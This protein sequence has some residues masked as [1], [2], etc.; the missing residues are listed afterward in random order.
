MIEYEPGTWGLRFIFRI[1]G[2]VLQKAL[3]FGIP[4]SIVAVILNIFAPRVD[5]EGVDTVWSNYTFVLG[6]LIVFR[7]NL[8]YSRFWEGASLIQQVRG[9]WLNAVS[10]LIAF[11]NQADGKKSDVAKFQHLL[12]RLMSMLHCSA[13]QQI[14]EVEDDSFEIL[15]PT[16]IDPSRLQFLGNNHTHRCEI[17]LQWIQRLIVEAESAGTLKVAPPILSRVYQ[18]LSRGIVNLHNVRRIKEVPFPFPYAQMITIMMLIHLIVTPV[19]ASQLCTTPMWSGSLTL[20]V[21]TA[22]WS[23]QYIALEIEQPFGEDMNDLPVAAFQSEMN[24]SLTLLLEPEVQSPP[25]FEFQE[26]R[27]RRDVQRKT[28][29]TVKFMGMRT[30]IASQVLE[31]RPRGYYADIFS[32]SMSF[33]RG[34]SPRGAPSERSSFQFDEVTPVEVE[35]LDC[36]QTPPEPHDNDIP[37]EQN[38][39][40]S[41]HLHF[42]SSSPD[43]DASEPPVVAAEPCAWRVA[44]LDA[45]GF[46]ACILP[47]IQPGVQPTRAPR[48]FGTPRYVSSPRGGCT[49]ANSE[50]ATTPRAR[51]AL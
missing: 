48:P 27:A 42:A 19:L 16:G 38:R 29:S 15:L 14:A 33:L 26:A 24:D 50:E 17:L 28:H 22:F 11:S 47:P 23:M 25:I 7:N 3:A 46:E 6:F 5:I 43:G 36:I 32:S 13:L 44:G 10:S 4:S 1:K 9:E 45:D 41:S 39:A 8:A 49:R 51:P 20:C 37:Q 30:S 12:V 18:E 34:F 35:S 2:S 21:V 40:F 31:D